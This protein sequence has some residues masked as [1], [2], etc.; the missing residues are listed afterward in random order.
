[1]PYFC[2]YPTIQLKRPPWAV[3]GLCGLLSAALSLSAGAAEK[4]TL[5]QALDRVIATDETIGIADLEVRKAR[6]EQWRALTSRLAPSLSVGA[7]ANWRGN[8]TKQTFERV[9][10]VEPGGPEQN[11]DGTVTYTPDITR[12]VRESRWTRSHSNAQSI[13]FSFNQPILDFTLG[14]ARRQ[15][16]LT[17]RIAEWQLRQRLREVLFGVTEQY[18]EVLKQER[19]LDENRKTLE[20]AREQ[21]RQAQ[22]RF[23]VQEVIYND[24]LQAQVDYERAHRAVLETENSLNFARSRLAVALSYP[25]TTV[26]ELKDPPPGRLPVADMQQA[27]ALAQAQREDVRV[28][29]LNLSRT[30]TMRDGIKARYAPTVDFQFSKDLSTSNSI[31]RSLNWTAGV[32]LNWTLFDRGQRELDLQTNQLQLNQ[33]GLRIDNMLRTVANDTLSS[34]FA[35]DRLKRQMSSLKTELEAAE[36]SYRVQ[37]ERYRAGLST[38]L[39]VLTALRDLANAR[40]G[41]VLARYELE[42][43]YRDL[44]NTVAAYEEDRIVRALRLLLPPSSTVPGAEQR[45]PPPP[46]EAPAKPARRTLFSTK[47]KPSSVTSHKKP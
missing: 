29:Q 19:L 44:E 30:Y 15:T 6:I 31:D 16:E 5:G 18:F 13:G 17:R 24:V 45:T 12:V 32:G 14:P 34:W 41:L 22:A 10:V 2:L 40:A 35:I 9:E 28:A 26:F 21:V 37:E 42:I 25:P 39:E 43:S 20:Q 47:P 11:P 33:D 36:V 46:P 4:L 38:S 8:R 27:I 23:E 1:M 3:I 7:D